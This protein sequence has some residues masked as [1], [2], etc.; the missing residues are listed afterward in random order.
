MKPFSLLKTLV[1]FS[2]FGL[3]LASCGEDT[4]IPG[5]DTSTPP[6]IKLNEVLGY[7][8]GDSDALI[9]STFSVYLTA[10]KGSSPLKTLSIYQDGELID[11]S[12]NRI[13]FSDIE[14]AANPLLLL[15]D[16]TTSFTQGVTVTVHNYL[17]VADYTFVVTDENGK[18]AGVALLINAFGTEITTLQGVLLNQSGPAGQGG[19]DLET[20]ASTGTLDTN[21]SSANADIRDEGIINAQTDQT[22][23]QQISGMN[24]SVIRNIF[25]GYN[26]VSE[27]FTFEGVQYQEEIAALWD[28]GV[29]FTEVSEDG[30]RNVSDKVFVGDM[31]IVKNGDGKLF[32]IYTND[33]VVTPND[34]QDHYVFDIKY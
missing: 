13:S 28:A 30:E 11:I 31:F 3:F 34:N 19:L 25:A 8:T 10:D 14:G 33:V 26:G 23:K 6:T 24:G 5:V 27:N 1:V 2:F 29:D 17:G 15:G 21:P 16:N 32:L 12:S 9:G 18:T 22:W 4:D 20:G 7:I